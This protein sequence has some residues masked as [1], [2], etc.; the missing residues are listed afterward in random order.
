MLKFLK[1]AVAVASVQT[2]LAVENVKEEVTTGAQVPEAIRETDPTEEAVA[3][4]NQGARAISNPT[5]MAL[6]IE[7]Q[8]VLEATSNQPIRPFQN[9]DVPDVNRLFVNIKSK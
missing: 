9:P 5:P 1:T 6:P 2:G 7:L 3:T 8:D 4:P